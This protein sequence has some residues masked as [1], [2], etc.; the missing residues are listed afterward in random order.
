M[1]D[2]AY[3]DTFENP[4]EAYAEFKKAMAYVSN[5]MNKGMDTAAKGINKVETLTEI[6]N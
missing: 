6:L 4:E 2:Y 5:K 1:V 3:N